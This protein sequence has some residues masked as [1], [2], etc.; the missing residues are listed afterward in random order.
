MEKK[1]CPKCESR[2]WMTDLPVRTQDGMMLS[3]YVSTSWKGYLGSTR[4]KASIC[5]ECGYSE[6]YAE[7]PAKVL[8]EWRKQNA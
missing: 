8:E 3:A 2:H 5:G 6:L 1:L 7:E 4:F